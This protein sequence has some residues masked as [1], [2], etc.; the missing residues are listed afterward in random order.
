MFR[1]LFV[2]AL[3]T[4]V[5][6]ACH[7]TNP[8]TADLAVVPDTLVAYAMTGTSPAFPSAFST[9]ARTVVR[10]DGSAG[11]DVAFDFDNAGNLVVMPVRLVVNSVTGAP[12]VGIRLLPGASYD[13]ISRAPSGYYRPDTAV[14]VT[15]GEPF[16]LLA[17]R[18]GGS[19]VCYT[20]ATPQIYAKVVVDSVKPLTTRAIYFR[21][22]VDLN[23]GYRSLLPGLPTH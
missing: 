6:A 2:V 13:T 18:N 15:P 10:V 1:R 20:L 8:I 9:V 14:T 5:L 16:I 17:N 22:A 19:T 21:T 3:A 11:F 23:C 4:T 7:D 12:A